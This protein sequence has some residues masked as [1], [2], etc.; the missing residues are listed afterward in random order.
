MTV[1]SS[2]TPLIALDAVVIHCETTSLD[3]REA[4]IVEIAAVRIFNGRLQEATAFRRLVHPGNAIPALSTQTHGI[5]DDAVADAPPFADVW[6]DL[7]ALLDGAIVIGHAIGFD[8]A[9]LKRECKRAGLAWKRPRTLDTRL[10]A[11]VAE[12]NLAGFSLDN[13]GAWLNVEINGRHTARG[14][15]LA[16]AHIFLALLS[17]LR[18][19]GIRTLGDAERAH[20]ALTAVL[21]ELHRAGWIEPAE[22]PSGLDAEHA[23]RRIDSYAYR[24]RIGEVM[25]APAEFMADDVSIGVAL[26]HMMQV[27]VSSVFVHCAAPPDDGTGA[28]NIG[29]LTER[30]ILRAV[31][32]QGAAALE[33]PIRRLMNAPLAT[34]PVDAFVYRAIGRMDRLQVRHLGVIDETG[35]IVG[36]VSARDVLCLRASGGISLGDEI[37][38]THTASGLAVAWAKSSQV[39]AALAADDV[40]ARDIAAVISRE[41]GAV[42]RQAAEIAEARM[43][44]SGHGGPPCRFA[45]AV[46]GE[47]G[48]GETL[49]TSRQAHALIFAAG[50]PGGEEDRWFER[51]AVHLA[52]ILDAAGVPAGRDSLMAKNPNWRGSVATWRTRIDRWIAAS[53][54]QDLRTVGPFFDLR[55]IHGDG[56]LANLVRSQAFA[57]A[58]DQI[59]FATLLADATDAP[60]TGLTISGAIKIDQGRVDLE[61]AGIAPIV[62]AARALAVRHHVLDRSTPDRLAAIKSAEIGGAD[63]LDALAEAHDI[64]LDLVLTQQ[65]HDLKHGLPAGHAVLVRGLN[66][67]ARDRMR[68]AVETAATLYQ[69]AREL[70]LER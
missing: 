11:E 48:R 23:L 24:H 25:R 5:D 49:L 6:P 53:N 55:G 69:R 45:L 26:A 16:C 60:E 61:R 43:S 46:L 38:H 68:F 65:I 31:A 40:P 67:R 54:V 62:A 33:L 28:A 2:D 19:G 50:D 14:D 27:R 10:L 1:L 57:A 13:L 66:R 44:A 64:L 32:Q 21:E 70:L 42:T 52:E 22:V 18:E 63:D 17:R 15:V 34:V 37:D 35:E 59:L 51:Y 7:A 56:G 29:I 3:P 58:R 47:A 8:L 41:L 12:P 30:D 36:A 39:A 20:S 9:V 4:W